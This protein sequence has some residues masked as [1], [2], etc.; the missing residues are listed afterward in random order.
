MLQVETGL[1]GGSLRDDGTF[2]PVFAARITI[3]TSEFA[4]LGLGAHERPSAVPACFRWCHR[5]FGVGGTRWNVVLPEGGD[6]VVCFA[7]VQ[8]ALAFHT[9][10]SEPASAA[11]ARRDAA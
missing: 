7:E 1:F 11:E 3:P 9:R 5:V 8:D 6:A 2:G 10:W 4:R